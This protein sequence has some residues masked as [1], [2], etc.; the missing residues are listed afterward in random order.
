M[1]EGAGTI[2]AVYKERGFGFLLGRGDL[3]KFFF[4]LRNVGSF[5]PEVGQ[6]SDVFRDADPERRSSQCNSN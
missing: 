6:E 4:A 3:E 5:E 1:E 2:V